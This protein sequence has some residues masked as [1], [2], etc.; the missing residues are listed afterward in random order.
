M[1][2]AG[3]LMVCNE[4]KI[5]SIKYSKDVFGMTVQIIYCCDTLSLFNQML[6][7]GKLVLKEICKD[8]KPMVN[9]L[10]VTK[11]STYVDTTYQL[12]TCLKANSFR[13]IYNFRGV[14]K[15]KIALMLRAE[16]CILLPITYFFA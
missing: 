13:L 10:R 9:N 2:K 5:G 16:C 8:K 14:L 15:I 3:L 1:S 4:G 12:L 6:V 7:I 11:L